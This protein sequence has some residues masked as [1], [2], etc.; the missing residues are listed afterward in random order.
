MDPHDIAE[1]S[2]DDAAITDVYTKIDQQ[3]YGIGY[4]CTKGVTRVTYKKIYFNLFPPST[5]SHTYNV[6][7]TKQDCEEM[8]KFKIC[9]KKSDKTRL[10]KYFCFNIDT[11]MIPSSTNKCY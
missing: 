9:D 10:Y 6:E 1:I 2:E 4:K 5:D 8:Q 11:I 3:V 7:L